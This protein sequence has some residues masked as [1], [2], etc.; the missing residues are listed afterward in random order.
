MAKYLL[1]IIIALVTI[2]CSG[3]EPGTPTVQSA[4]AQA[5]QSAPHSAT[6]FEDEEE[7]QSSATFTQAEIDDFIKVYPQ[8]K[9]ARMMN[10]WLEDNTPGT[11]A[12]SGLVD[13][14]DQTVVSPQATVDY[15][16]NWFSLS[17]GPAIISAPAYDKFFSVAIYDMFHNVP[18]V[19]VNPEKPIIVLRP[20]Q[21][22]P[23][24]DAHI[25]PLETDQGLIFTRML[26]VDNLADVR[27]LSEE[28]TMQGGGGDM[29]YALDPVPDGLEAATEAYLFGEYQRLN[30]LGSLDDGAIPKV[31]GDVPSNYLAIAVMIG[32]LATPSDSVQYWLALTD[33]DGQPIDPSKTYRLDVPAGLVEESGYIS[34]TPYNAQTRFLIPN[35]LGIYDRTSYTMEAN[36]DG[37]YSVILSP[38]GSG[39]NGLPTSGVPFY[40]LLRAYVPVDGANVEATLSEMANP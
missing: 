37:S 7:E 10:R 12:F 5:D 9:Q 24:I 26:V 6:G 19:I 15:G 14:N 36:A 35:E 29:S 2:G 1:G 20:G 23:D 40:V 39:Q 28:I 32:Q 31:S 30:A 17:D 18:A 38:E 22:A 8:I 25:V 3:S 13:P 34:I 27:A 4:E 21:T 16:Y 33:K 11:F